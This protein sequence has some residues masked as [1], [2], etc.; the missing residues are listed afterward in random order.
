MKKITE[1]EVKALHERCSDWQ[2]GEKIFFSSKVDQGDLLLDD[3]TGGMVN[4]IRAWSAQF[5]A[6]QPRKKLVWL[7]FSKKD[8]KNPLKSRKNLIYPFTLRD[9]HRHNMRRTDV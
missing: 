3:I 4:N 8:V 6:Y 5:Y 7:Q 2:K 9:V 1:Q